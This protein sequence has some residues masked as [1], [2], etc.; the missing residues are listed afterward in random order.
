ME[1]WTGASA[2]ALRRA[3]RMSVRDFAAHLGVAS[4]TVSYW[5][6]KGAAVTPLPQT[7]DILDAALDTASPGAARRF[8]DLTAQA[9]PHRHRHRLGAADLNDWAEDL[10]RAR[11]AVARQHFDLA[12]RLTDRWLA[13]PASSD[14]RAAE[15]RALT[16]LAAG[17]LRRDQGQVVGPASAQQHYTAAGSLFASLGLARRSAQTELVLGVVAEMSGAL[18]RAAADYAR[19]A[20]DERLSDRDRARSLLWTGTAL[21]K[22]GHH[23]A[24]SERMHQAATAFERLGEVEDW[25]V[26]HQKLALVHRSVG[27]LDQAHEAL[28][29]AEAA[30][31]A[32]TPLQQVRLWTAR[33]HVLLTDRATQAEGEAVLG[34]ALAV[35]A[36]YG[37]GHQRRSIDA[38]RTQARR[39]ASL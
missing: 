15:L 12:A 8:A 38:I 10:D 21:T 23:T 29:A 13:A 17:D 9:A 2:A 19:L 1:A 34:E 20:A 5:E 22:Q 26:A 18:D 28:S 39:G 14:D 36:R 7:Q 33:G 27:R 30:G 4:R 32:A 25:A 3:M 31:T 24:A 11:E 16:L 35:C 37:L 6:A